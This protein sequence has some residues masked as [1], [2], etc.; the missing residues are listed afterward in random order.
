MLNKNRQ[1]SIPL[2]FAPDIHASSLDVYAATP[3]E[4]AEAI[5]ADNEKVGLLVKKLRIKAG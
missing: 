4:F 3:G 5:R 1:N 2:G